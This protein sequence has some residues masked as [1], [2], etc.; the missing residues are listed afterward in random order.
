MALLGFIIF[1]AASRGRRTRQTRPTSLSSVIAVVGSGAVLAP[2]V[3][4]QVL[5]YISTAMRNLTPGILLDLGG[6]R[7]FHWWLFPLPILGAVACLIVSFVVLRRSRQ[8]PELPVIPVTRRTW[9]SF[10]QRRDVVVAACALSALVLVSVLAGLASVTDDNGLH[11]LLPIGG[12][13]LEPAGDSNPAA[14]PTGGRGLRNLLWLGVL[15][16]SPGGGDRAR[17]ID[18]CVPAC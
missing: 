10:T 4:V 13:N 15:C 2:F 11:T 6:P 9:L 7:D 17:L 3:I 12:G 8:S 16:A 5:P 18:L 1:L 14:P